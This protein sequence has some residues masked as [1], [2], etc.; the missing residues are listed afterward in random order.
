MNSRTIAYFCSG[1]LLHKST[2]RKLGNGSHTLVKDCALEMA[3]TVAVKRGYSDIVKE[4]IDDGSKP[5]AKKFGYFSAQT[6]LDEAIENGHADVVRVL[7][8]A[9]IDLKKI[10]EAGSC[11]LTTACRKGRIDIVKLLLDKG[12]SANDGSALAAA[13]GGSYLPGLG[14]GHL[15]VIKLLVERGADVNAESGDC[16]DP[17][18][19]FTVTALEVAAREGHLEVVRYLLEKGADP[20]KEMSCNSDTGDNAITFAAWKGHTGIVKLF[21]DKGEDV[22]GQTSGGITAL[23]AASSGAKLETAQ[24][25]LSRGANVNAADKEG[26]TPLFYALREPNA[27][28]VKLLIEKGADPNIKNGEGLTVLDIAES[29]N[30]AEIAAILRAGRPKEVPKREG[31]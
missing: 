19:D 23:M 16:L 22:N 21:L 13:A 1:S 12:A 3:F 2:P 5:D 28:L 15:D 9:G 6:L 25:L 10:Q 20:K 24:F 18:G 14:G 26:K 31:K 30:L 4:M 17:S 11:P 8:D 27:A 7:L 29:E